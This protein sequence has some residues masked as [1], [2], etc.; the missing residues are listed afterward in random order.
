MISQSI[1]SFCRFL[2][3]RG[4]TPGL[5]QTLDSMAAARVVNPAARAEFKAALKAILSS[6][7]EDWDLF[8][9]LFEEFF[10]AQQ[11]VG[12]V[13]S[14]AEQKRKSLPPRASKRPAEFTQFLEGRNTEDPTGQLVLGASAEDRLKKADFSTVSASD[15]DELDRLALRLL[16]LISRRISRRFRRFQA[17][18]RFDLR[19]TIRRSVTAGGVPTSLR[20]K[21]RK[22]RPLKL[23][24]L[25]DVSGSMNPY[26][27]F[28]V[29]LA[30][31]LQKHFKQVATFLFSTQIQEITRQL[32]ARQLQEALARLSNEKAGWSGGTRI[33]ESLR[34]FNEG[35]GR[36]LLTRRT[37]FIILSDG[38]DTGPPELLAQQVAAIQRRTRRLIWLNPLLG[39]E[40]YQPV[41]RALSAALPFVDIFVPAHNLES[42]LQLESHLYVRS[43]SK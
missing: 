33:G 41:T 25:L 35:R 9:G 38:W 12:A 7:K 22:L 18:G 8:D 32:R 10:T 26:S 6:S 4:L 43:I 1:V 19:A 5:Q 37:V 2:R 16:S 23:V 24:I 28:L 3:E 13:S 31:A 42:L 36:R 39:M 40:D 34:T 29:R 17:R 14:P 11:N 20:F 21:A 30:Y 27:L 15:S